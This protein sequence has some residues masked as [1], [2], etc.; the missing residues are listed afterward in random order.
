MA[1]PQLAKF[2]NFES[3]QIQITNIC[4]IDI[5]NNFHLLFYILSTTWTQ[6]G[7]T[8]FKFQVLPP[9]KRRHIRAC[10]LALM[11]Y[12]YTG[13]QKK[14]H[15]IHSIENGRSTNHFFVP[16]SIMAFILGY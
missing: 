12:I 11:L 10:A 16:I 7:E 3:D 14:L 9:L 6:T 8:L 1:T 15:L 2:Q 13:Q 5:L 4:R